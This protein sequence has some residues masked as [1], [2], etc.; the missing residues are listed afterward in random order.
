MISDI[1]HA[2]IET[3][4]ALGYAGIVGLMFIE[5]SFIPFPSELVMPPAGY[6]A[7]MGRMNVYAVVASGLLGSMLGA[8]FNYYFAVWVGEPF[9]RRYGR[10]FFVSGK[11]LDKSEAFFRRH[12]EVSTFVGRLTPVVR[13][14]ISVPAGLA[15]MNLG[16]FLAFTA[17]GAGIWCAILTY[18]GWL[19]GRHGASMAAAAEQAKE[20]ASEIVVF[21]IIP[22]LLVIIVAYA[23]WYNRRRARET[24]A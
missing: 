15:R 5:S 11:A 17:L 14:L 7:A 19:L 2:I 10:Y 3:V 23:F 9:L 21:Y 6:L 24:G 16:K 20:Q 12:G 8:L 13:Q 22:A 1:V 4:F 18:I